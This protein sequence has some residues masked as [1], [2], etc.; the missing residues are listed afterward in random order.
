MRLVLPSEVEV[1]DDY[2]TAEN[3]HYEVM[4]E[5]PCVSN[6]LEKGH[7]SFV[8]ARPGGTEKG[9]LRAGSIEPSNSSKHKFKTKPDKNSKLKYVPKQTH[10]AMGE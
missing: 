2:D 3:G 8:G 7:D 9:S 1:F 5:K 10:K 4:P 6:G